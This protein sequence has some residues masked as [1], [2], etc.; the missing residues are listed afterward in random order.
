[1]RTYKPTTAFQENNELTEQLVT[2][3]VTFG[4]YQNKTIK[5]FK[6]IRVHCSNVQ[7]RSML[8]CIDNSNVNILTT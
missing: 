2:N 8:L 1:M 5:T 3:V 7:T 4:L 6:K